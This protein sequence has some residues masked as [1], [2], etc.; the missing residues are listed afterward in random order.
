MLFSILIPTLEDRQDK[1]N[2]IYSKLSQQISAN[3]LTNKAEILFLLDNREHS[4]GYKRNELMKLA[5]GKFIAFVDDDDD[6]SDDY[7]PLICRTI[8]EN[9]EIDCIGIKGIISFCGN[10][11]R[12]FIHS[13]RYKKYFTKEGT[14]FR[15]P[16]H[17]NPIKREIAV[18]YSFEDISYS[19]DIDWALRICRDQALQKEYFLDQIIYYYYS[20]RVWS[21]QRLLDRSEPLRH[22]LGLQLV[23]RIIIKRRLKNLFS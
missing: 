3:S 14:Y 18:K 22:A 16:Y 17:L 23:N 1:F 2:N 5:K 10:N 8:E 6:V 20:R 11:P 15:P 4:I 12:I 7:V 19:E 13:L 9:P 21:Y